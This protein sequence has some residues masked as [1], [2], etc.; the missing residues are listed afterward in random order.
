MQMVLPRQGST[1][2]HPPRSTTNKMSWNNQRSR[3][4]MPF[5]G[6]SG[7]YKQQQVYDLDWLPLGYETVMEIHIVL[8]HEP[9]ALL[10]L[11]GD[12]DTHHLMIWLGYLFGMQ[13]SACLCRPIRRKGCATWDG[14]NSTWGGRARVFGTVSVCVS[15][16]EMAGGEGRVLAGKVVKGNPQYALQDQGI[17]DSGCF[18]HMTGNKSYLTDYQEI[19]GRFVAFG[20]NAKGGNQTNGNVGTKANIDAGQAG[21]KTVPGP[22]YVLLPLLIT[23]SQGPNSLEDEIVDDAGIKNPGRERAQSNKFKSMFGQDNDVNGNMMFT[24]DTV[25]LQDS[26]IFSGTYDDEVEGAGADFNNLELTTIVSPIPTTR[27]HKD[28]PKE[29]II[30]DPLSA[31]Q[32]R[33]MTMTSQE[34][35][36]VYVD[37]IIFGSTKKSLCTEFE[38]LMHKK[39]QISSMR[40]LTFFLGLQVMQKDDRS[41]DKYVADIL[42]KLYFSSVK[43]AGTLIETN[44]ALLKDEEAK[45]VDVYL[46]RS[47]IGSLM[48]LTASRP[49]IIYLKG[50]PKLGLWYPKDSP[51]NLEAFSDGDYAGASLDRK[52]PT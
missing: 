10:S 50:Q 32:T 18:R 11:N 43:T 1:Y 20:G 35:A 16:Q 6:I 25:D 21:K 44:K 31:L 9:K 12:D 26:E 47:M 39:F 28:H 42:K 27:I 36:M 30:K 45:D 5:T 2:F 17:F 3:H 22:Q 14:G 24:T 8:L 37:D 51:F 38:G 46:Y 34:H 15:V 41:Q 52:S 19:D 13:P 23:D 49:G 29:Q 40:D 48:Y 7:K 33:R 4:K